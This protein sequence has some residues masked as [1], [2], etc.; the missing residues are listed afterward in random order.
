MSIGF[1]NA[2]LQI[3][4]ES[5]LVRPKRGFSLLNSAKQEEMFTAQVT[6][7][8][9]HRDT[10]VITDHP[11]EFGANITDHAFKQPVSL[12]L[13]YGWSNSPTPNVAGGILGV[14]AASVGGNTALAVGVGLGIQSGMSGFNIGNTDSGVQNTQ[15]NQVYQRLLELQQSRVPFSIFTGKRKYDDMLIQEMEVETDNELENT[16]I[17]TIH[18]RQIIIAQTSVVT[19][20]KAKQA[21]PSAT[22]STLNLGS[23][24]PTV[25]DQFNPAGLY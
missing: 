16:L 8:E 18:C 19:L 17:A 15:V 2:A 20:P 6:I 22:A 12:V 21:D 10:L 7:E 9:T 11:V 14:A 4:L 23:V 1:V 24:F 5:I 3:G 13:R 25:S